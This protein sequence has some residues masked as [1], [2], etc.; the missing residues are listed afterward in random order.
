MS[1]VYM[2]EKGRQ[3]YL[4]SIRKLEKELK[5]IIEEKAYAYQ[6][7]SNAWHDNFAYEDATRKEIELTTTINDMKKY[8]DDIE[9]IEEQNIEGIVDINDIVV[10]ETEDEEMIV[11]VIG[12]PT[13]LDREILE[14]SINS[15]LGSALYGKKS[16]D[17]ISYKVEEKVHSGFIKRINQ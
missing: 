11:K 3:D 4:E 17:K 7:D 16:G 8:L 15:P 10:F 1:K 5:E 2:D 14:V 13:N 6:N 9:I 12:G